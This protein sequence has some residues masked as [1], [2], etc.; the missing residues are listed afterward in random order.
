MSKPKGITSPGKDIYTVDFADFLPQSLKK[1]PKIRAL[2]AAVT[3]QLLSVSGNIEKVLIYSRFDEL[4]E[5]LIDILAY[6]L[7][8][9]WYDYSFPLKAKRELVKNS[10]KVHKKMGTKYAVETA[11][12][13]VYPQSEVEEWF[14]YNG[15]PHHFRVVCDVTENEIQ[16]SYQA[17]VDAVKMYKRLSAHLDD[18]T[19]QCRIYCTIQTHTDCF[20]Y[21]SPYTGRLN[22]GTYPQRNVKGVLADGGI[23]IETKS[24]G[25][26]YDSPA[27]GTL[28]ERNILFRYSETQ[29][30]AET[31][32]AAN[33]Y[34][35]AAAGT[36]PERNIL[37]GASEALIEAG[38]EGDVFGYESGMTGKEKA[39]TRPERNVLFRDSE[40]QIEAETE[41]NVFR[42]ESGM[43]GKEKAGT[44]PERNVLFRDSEAQIEAETES[45]VHE[46]ASCITGTLPERSVLLRASDAQ[47]D[48]ETG[49]N[50]YRYRNILSG[51]KNAGMEPQ[52]SSK[53]G[54]EDGE[55]ESTVETE[56]F[57]HNSKL[58]GSKRRL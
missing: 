53:G 31:D 20:I 10:V 52:R 41:R 16:A 22:A 58:C 6:D 18:V 23:I 34:T 32:S 48:A 15:N 36:L 29:I 27:A 17:I 57:I 19:F 40:A 44:R 5:D 45:E 9:D 25:F 12:G 24:A 1:D 33:K 35:S 3:E 42:Y 37:F 7:H 4:P 14:Q 8:V 28:P 54:N 30:E 50:T 55:M 47:I 13:G 38:T 26:L 56:S 49:V 39:G 43:T 51:E 2:A 11:L 21:H 46:Y